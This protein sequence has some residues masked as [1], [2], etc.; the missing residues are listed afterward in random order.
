M[1]RVRNFIPITELY[2]LRDRI[3]EGGVEEDFICQYMS[4]IDSHIFRE[5]PENCKTESLCLYAV[6]CHEQNLFYI[7]EEKRTK[8]MYE[9][10]V[11]RNVDMIGS[12]PEKFM[13]FR[14][15]YKACCV[16]PHWI[17]HH[18]AIPIDQLL[19]DC[20]PKNLN[21]FTNLRSWKIRKP[22]RL[23]SICRLYLSCDGLV[24]Q[25]VLEPTIEECR[26]AFEQNPLALQWIP[27]DKQKE[28]VEEIFDKV[29]LNQA[30]WPLLAKSVHPHL[31][32][33]LQEAIGGPDKSLDVIQKEVIPYLF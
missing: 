32:K 23:S 25:W 20:L 2:K 8:Q 18:D 11:N 12:V 1:S 6:G 5:V 14:L 16:K 15:A 28:M 17:F 9:V 29:Q 10:A 33:L 7:P 4:L 31:A 30:L 21:S 24:L 26:I 19:V 27:E 3:P 22:E 13:T